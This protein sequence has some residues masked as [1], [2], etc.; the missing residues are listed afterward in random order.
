MSVSMY[1]LLYVYMTSPKYRL[2]V[3][4]HICLTPNKNNAFKLENCWL[5]LGAKSDNQPTRRAARWHVRLVQR[6]SWEG[7]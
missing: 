2:H 3:M 4:C 1:I 5:L 7:E 6:A